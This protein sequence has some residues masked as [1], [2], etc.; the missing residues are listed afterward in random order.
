MSR[1]QRIRQALGPLAWAL[2]QEWPCGIYAWELPIDRV[3]QG[4][5]YDELRSR[6]HDEL[7]SAGTYAE[8]FEE[9]AAS[10]TVENIP[11]V[12]NPDRPRIAVVRFQQRAQ[13]SS[14]GIRS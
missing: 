3:I 14:R 6:V 5:R 4:N 1:G 12:P 9:I 8:A 2:E 7:T 10:M 11:G 13:H